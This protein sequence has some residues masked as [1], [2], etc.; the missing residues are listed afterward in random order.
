MATWALSRQ[1]NQSVIRL[2][3]FNR[4]VWLSIGPFACFG[5]RC[6]ENFC[7]IH[8]SQV[9]Q[10]LNASLWSVKLVLLLW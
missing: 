3:R 1:N 2:G 10:K 6:N 5:E 9:Y 8:G 4:V 7:F